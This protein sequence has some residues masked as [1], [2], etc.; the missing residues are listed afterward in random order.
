MN[1]RVRDGRWILD[2][3]GK[4]IPNK[5]QKEKDKRGKN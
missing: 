2:K 5:G 4:L 3:N 1:K